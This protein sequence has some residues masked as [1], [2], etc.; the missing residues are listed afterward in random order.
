MYKCY[1]IIF[2]INFT[3]TSSWANAFW[4]FRVYSYGYTLSQFCLLVL[5]LILCYVI[6]NFIFFG[7]VLYCVLLH[8]DH[9]HTAYNHEMRQ[10]ITSN[11][12]GW[13]VSHTNISFSTDERF[14]TALG[15]SISLFGIVLMTLLFHISIFQHQCLLMW[16]RYDDITCKYVI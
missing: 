8:S 5:P 13:Y 10:H 16:Q 15:T 7:S 12:D 9:I 4:V 2:G 14:I 1:S 6:C 3:R 11:D